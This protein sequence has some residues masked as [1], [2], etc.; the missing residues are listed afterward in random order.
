MSA[1]RGHA[2]HPARLRLQLFRER[3]LARSPPL[4]RK[5]TEQPPSQEDDD[6]H[7][8]WT[9]GQALG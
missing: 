8:P 6:D 5:A 2:R 1:E 4:D 3:R 7:L 9:I